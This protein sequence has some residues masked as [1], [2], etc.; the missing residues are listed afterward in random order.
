VKFQAG[1]FGRIGM[2]DDSVP[3]FH[4]PAPNVVGFGGYNGRGIA[5]GT[6]FGR[7]LARH[8]LGREDEMPLPT[9]SAVEAKHR[10]VKGAYYEAGAQVA[11]MVEER[12]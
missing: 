7:V 5:P 6:V 3:R 11:H 9:T 8:I 4:V 2:T 1:W 12:G 10:G